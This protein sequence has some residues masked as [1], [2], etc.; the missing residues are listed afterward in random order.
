MRAPVSLPQ[1][2][3]LR[4]S[5]LKGAA[6]ATLAGPLMVPSSVLGLDGR[7]SAANRI[8]MGFIGL[9]G[10]GSGHLFGGAWTY[11]T[12]G[13]LGRDEVQVL[14]V[15]DVWRNKREAARQR[16]NDYY[17]AKSGKTVRELTT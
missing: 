4:R 12:G 2:A 5:F 1:H 13:Y 11:L 16:V 17:A 6:A 9:G 8:T 7:V 15:C 10:Q 14:G 3:I